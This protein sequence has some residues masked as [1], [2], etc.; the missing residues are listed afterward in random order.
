MKRMTKKL[1]R[2]ILL[3][4]VLV[5]E[6]AVACWVVLKCPNQVDVSL[7]EFQS[8]EAGMRAAIKE[9]AF[10]TKRCQEAKVYRIVWD[11]PESGEV[12]AV[13]EDS[14]GRLVVYYMPPKVKAMGF[15]PDVYR[16]VLGSYLV[17]RDA[18]TAVAAKGG[19]FEDFAKYDQGCRINF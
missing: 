6:I 5:A 12:A 1:R 4:T 19:T 9:L 8:V 18:I 14:S 13:S 3:S 17:D 16:G 10:E 2:F 7:G 15:E 11:G